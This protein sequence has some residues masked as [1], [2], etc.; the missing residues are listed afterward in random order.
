MSKSGTIICKC[1]SFA[2]IITKII[3]NNNDLCSLSG[4]QNISSESIH[5]LKIYNNPNLSY[6]NVSSICGFLSNPTGLI[7]IYNNKTGCNTAPEIADSCNINL[8]CL[9]YGNYYLLSQSDVDNFRENYSNCHKLQ[10]TTSRS[11]ACKTS[12]GSGMIMG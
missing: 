4:L 12:V 5:F 7:D 9:P 3:N 6:C 2:G 1:V 11:P 10:G 8:S